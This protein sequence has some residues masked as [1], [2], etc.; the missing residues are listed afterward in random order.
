[1]TQAA[2]HY[3][4]VWSI[5]ERI[6]HRDLSPVALAD[7]MLA[8]IA[9]LDPDLH[10]Y[11]FLHA[12]GVRRQAR[13]AE[14]A[15]ARDEQI[16]ALHGV[17]VAVKD[18]FWTKDMPSSAGMPI[19][20]GHRTAIDATVVDRLR[21]AGAIILGKLEMTEGAFALHHPAIEPPRNPWGADL[22]PGA[23]SSGAGV[24]TAAGLCFAS[25]GTDTGGSI[26]FPCAAN[27]LTGIKPTWGRVSRHGSFVFADSLD[28]VGPI[29]RSAR[30]AALLLSVIS[31][32]DPAD[33]TS[34]AAF[35]LPAASDPAILRGLRVG[36]DPEWN[37]EDCDPEIGAAIDAALATLV[38]LGAT[39]CD[40]RVPDV[41]PAVEQWELIAGV[42]AAVAHHRTFPSRAAD[43][44]PALARLLEIGHATSGIAYQR[45]LLDR[46]ALRGR[47]NAL[48]SDIDILVAP[49][50]P[51]AAPTLERL[52]ALADSPDANYRLIRFT[53]PFNLSGHPAIALP[54]GETACGHPIG[55][56]M[57][58]AHQDEMTLLS[59]AM[60]FQD[61]SAWHRRRPML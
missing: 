5:A 52:G 51:Y 32:Q 30:D 9:A 23:S 39:L 57:V 35:A 1:M 15:L 22:W 41:R 7:H 45:A 28:H 40:V 47:L 24:A 12:D 8:R 2:L 20:H 3:E 48:L 19:Y 11:A 56:Q 17:P 18:L 59:A 34:I 54:C 25:L 53:A 37:R 46:M 14:A 58:A 4:D 43:Y 21:D 27:G 44:G 33:P 49:V 55:L 50:Q 16:G 36:T 60:A 13:A 42:E 38:A 61:K 10:S 29:A 31:G 26:R 6:R